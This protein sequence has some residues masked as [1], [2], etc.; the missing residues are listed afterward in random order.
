[1]S[2]AP[3]TSETQFNGKDL[4]SGPGPSV[5]H[6]VSERQ[7]YALTALLDEH[8]EWWDGPCMCATCRSY[9]DA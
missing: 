2:D 5:M 3:R 7:L 6:T 4:L 9:I 1:M 8:P